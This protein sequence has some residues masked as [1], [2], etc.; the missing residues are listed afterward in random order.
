MSGGPAAA[1]SGPAPAGDPAAASGGPAAGKVAADAATWMQVVFGGAGVAIALV[2]A[3][4]AYFAWVQPHAPDEPT[5]GPVGTTGAVATTGSAPTATTGPAT[6]GPATTRPAVTGPATTGATQ[7]TGG[8]QVPLGRLA[9]SAGGANIHPAGG[10]LVMPCASGQATDRQRTVEYDLA[11][12]Y[13]GVTA[14]LRV[15]KAPDTDS[16]L[17]VKVFS[18][19]KEVANQ[20]VTGAASVPLSS[21]FSGTTTMRIQLTCQ[22]P[23]SEITFEN[24]TLSHM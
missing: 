18:D 20:N 24:P 2:A 23:D 14:R 10:D 15:S 17:Q 19:G 22:S 9:P 16:L 5:P 21:Q 12:R 6:T 7:A 3:V 13:T 8:R 4:F 11:G 1:G